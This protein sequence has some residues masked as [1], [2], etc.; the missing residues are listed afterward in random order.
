MIHE[1]DAYYFVHF[2]RSTQFGISVDGAPVFVSKND[3]KEYSEPWKDRVLQNGAV[4]K[5]SF[6]INKN[7][8]EHTLTLT[9]G[10]PGMMI[11]RIVIDWG[12]LKKSYVGPSFIS[13]K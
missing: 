8:T 5:T 3:H 11:Q 6:A 7:R 4:T 13:N 10:D 2:E 12:G 9:C 1:K